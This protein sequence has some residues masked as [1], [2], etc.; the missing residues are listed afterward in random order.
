MNADPTRSAKAAG[1]RYV[2]DTVPGIRRARH[3]D[4]FVYDTPNGQRIQ[5]EAVLQRIKKLAIPPAWTDVWISPR[6]DGHLQATGRDAKG[7]KQY[8][9]H[10]QWRTER[11]Q[12]KYAHMLA[13]GEALP[14]LRGQVSADLHR[15]GIPREKVLATIVRLLELTFIRIGNE[16]YA[17]HNDSYGL[18]T[19]HNDHVD[20]MGGALRF[21]FRGKSGKQH[22]IDVRDR[23]LAKIV[24]RCQDIAGHE[25]F[26][27]LDEA[28]CPH[29][30][31]SGDVNAYLR[32]VTGHD[33]TAKDF[34]TWGGTIL[35]VCALRRLPAAT[36]E[37]AARHNLVEAVKV[38]SRR[39]GNTPAVC[40]KAYIHPAVFDAYL[41]GRLLPAFA[42]EPIPDPDATLDRLHDYETSIMR[43]LHHE[44]APTG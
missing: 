23:H 34:R 31:E 27:Y 44:V 2:C 16:D 37:T 1:L 28:G 32:D 3:A 9:Y 6:P 4:T 29:A 14:T 30:V 8:R 13:F 41:A 17:R 15:P 26:Q 7:R 36:S 22:Q 12:S 33:I 43:F 19:L 25:L 24:K 38:V 21:H 11:D 39:L 18:T 10:L 5:D 40:R 35:A 20:I 42:R